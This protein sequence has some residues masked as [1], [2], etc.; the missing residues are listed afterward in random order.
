MK[1]IT[2]EIEQ[3]YRDSR[4]ERVKRIR[5]RK[6]SQEDAEDI[7]QETFY[8]ALKY[9]DT[10]N[11][12][13]QDLNVWLDIIMNNAFKSYRSANLNGDYSFTEEDEEATEDVEKD[14]IDQDTLDQIKKEIDQLNPDIRQVIYAY[15]VLG[16]SYKDCCK[17]FDVSFHA[18]EK[19][20]SRFRKKMKEKYG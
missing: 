11:P 13:L 4:D 8:R 14:S 16:Y 2:E 19:R 3:A 9:K 20:I 15:M 18:V 10:F 12:M 6:M 17:I 7:V 5:A 1:L